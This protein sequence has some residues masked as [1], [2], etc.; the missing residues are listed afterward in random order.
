MTRLHV[1]K[2][3]K[4]FT[5]KGT[6]AVFENSFAA[7][8]G[9]ITTLLGP[10]GSGKTTLLRVIAGLEAADS[11]YVFLDGEDI[12]TRPARERG[13]GFVF[14]TF[15]LFPQMTVRQNIAFG[16]E[17]RKASRPQIKQRVDELLSLIKLESYGDRFPGQLS[18][19]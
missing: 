11:G 14:Q 8:P 7:A 5:A 12:T 13:F 16:L 2:I 1:D 6:P 10:S 18:G 15:A 19:G 17:V 9:G 4:R 3:T